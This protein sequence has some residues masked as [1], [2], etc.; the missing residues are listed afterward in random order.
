MESFKDDVLKE[1]FNTYKGKALEDLSDSELRAL[2][3]GIGY[4]GRTRGK[5]AK[6][7]L[8]EREEQKAMEK[9]SARKALDD[10]TVKGLVLSGDYSNIGYRVEFSNTIDT[11][12]ASDLVSICRRRF[13]K[14]DI[15]L[16]V[17][18]PYNNECGFVFTEDKIY[19][20]CYSKLESIIEYS[21][22]E[23]ADFDNDSVIV[24]LSNGEE[25]TLDCGGFKGAENYSK[26]MYN[27]VMD[28][29]G[30]IKES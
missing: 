1:D 20:F 18:V 17:E 16:Y 4:L 6:E 2:S 25:T 8:A 28:I 19:S 27:L 22:I 26:H 24:K 9:E 15:I 3:I 30:R 11:D 29:V 10:G 7:I 23:N 12:T 13:K 14:E 21:E 5:R